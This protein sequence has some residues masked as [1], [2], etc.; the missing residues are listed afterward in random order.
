MKKTILK[1]VLASTLLLSMSTVSLACD[2]EAGLICTQ[3]LAALM[4]SEG[5]F[6][7]TDNTI[8]AYYG[9]DSELLIPCVIDETIITDIGH[10]A[11][12]G[13][14]E[15]IAAAIPD[16]MES[17][18]NGAFSYNPSLLTLKIPT[19]VTRFGDNIFIGSPNVTIY[20]EAGSFAEHYALAQGIPFV[21]EIDSA[22][23]STLTTVEDDETEDLL[24][25]AEDTTVDETEDLLLDGEDSTVDDT[26]T[27]EADTSNPQEEVEEN[28]ET[29][30]TTEE[31][32]LQDEVEEEILP[33]PSVIFHDWALET[34]Q[35]ANQKGLLVD[36]LG[37]DFTDDITRLQIAD[38]LVN[39]IEK[40]SKTTLSSADEG[41]FT[42]T[43]NISVRKAF[44]AGII[45]G[46]DEGIFA[47]DEFA[48]RQ[49]ISIMV[50]RAITTLE[51]ISETEFVNSEAKEA[52]EHEDFQ[53]VATW[54]QDFMAILV[55]NG[56]MSG[57]DNK[58]NPLSYTTI[59]EC[60]V[61]NNNLFHLS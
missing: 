37:T 27:T 56:I 1:G 48:T 52:P 3:T 23:T 11:F 34:V 24:L 4:D 2:I 38:L 10:F 51:S 9:T 61:L 49:E 21:P 50:Y 39:M 7:Y 17:I 25:D 8:T 32:D 31:E 47:P 5:T 44:E 30:D 16:S 60:L 20:A 58:L 14:T 59:Q 57:A 46:K 18:G 12:S 35:T 42:D 43:D 13:R 29:E 26:D 19:S 22:S 36:S 33:L 55:N 28:T 41:S 15:I 6:S 54:A 45:T 40:F 53:E